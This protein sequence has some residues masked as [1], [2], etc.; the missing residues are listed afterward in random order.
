MLKK[1]Y[2]CLVAGLP[3]LFFNENKLAISSVSFRD[4][5]K[6]Q[7]SQPD[8]HL[9]E[10]L[11]LSFDNENLLTRFFQLERPFNTQGNI[12]KENLEY[13][14]SPEN[15]HVELPVFM[16]QFLDWMKHRDSKELT[17]EVE[18]I[19]SVLFYEFVLNTKNEFLRNWF[20]FELNI[21][22][23]LTAFHCVQFDYELSEQ[24]LNVEQNKTVYNLLAGKRLKSELYED[25][26]PF[27]NQ[28][29]KIVESDL[30]LQ[31]KEKAIDKLKWDYLD[32]F[33]FFHYFTI[34]KILSYVIKLLLVERWMK[35]DIETGKQ[36]L[37]KLIEELKTSYEFPAEF[38][39]T[40]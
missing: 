10:Y 19:L 16:L 40:K 22:N 6:Y 14:F 15:E 21:K 20:M 13:Q 24:L 18:N 23:I 39:L 34:E 31:E 27:H 38:S 33:T 30:K 7:L 25:E 36:L 28:L 8:Y 29:F 9:V 17:V 26:V 2:Y 3:D 1:E 11:F 32:E 12:S 4:E 37:N 5:L 35:M